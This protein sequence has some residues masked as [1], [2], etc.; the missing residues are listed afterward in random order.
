MNGGG[1]NVILDNLIAQGK[2]VPMVVGD[3]AR[4]RRKQRPGR[5]IDSGEHSGLHEN[6]AE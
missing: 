5:R 3:H 2:A 4:L 6:P 1:A